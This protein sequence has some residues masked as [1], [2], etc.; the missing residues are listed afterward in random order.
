MN[1]FEGK[2]ALV[3]GAASGIGRGLCEELCAQGG[4]VYAADVNEAGL[5][6]L[7][8]SAPA[9]ATIIPVRLDVSQEADFEQAI[10]TLLKGHGK[11]DL[12]VNNAGIVLGGD[13]S[14]TSNEELR[15]L[16]DINLWGV[17]YGTQQAYR[18]MI[19][20]GHGH[21]VNVSSSA[22]SMPVP[23]STAYC[24]SKHAI[25][26]FSHSLREEAAL[27]GVKVSVVL[28]GMVKS[29]LWDA[30][31]NVK[32]YNYKA[33]MESMPL[34]QISPRQAGAAIVKGIAKNDR[35]IAFPLINK[36]ILRLYQLMPSIGTKLFVKS[37]VQ[38]L[39][40]SLAKR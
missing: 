25:V 20:Q 31:L 12:L 38:P 10:A 36:I 30:A 4:V 28:P 15:K 26:G 18:V 37:L 7:K 27:Y 8:S 39:A 34:K 11:L 22:G 6:E 23:M 32:D 24:A 29:G 9:K 16:F 21:I 19:K 5:Q 1:N 3:T 2:V 35:T 40:D 13:F 17:I 33:E 14:E